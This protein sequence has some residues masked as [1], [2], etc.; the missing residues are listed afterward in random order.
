MYTGVQH[1][2]HIGGFRIV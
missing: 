1:D 2:L